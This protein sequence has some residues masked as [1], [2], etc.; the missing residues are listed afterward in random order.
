MNATKELRDLYNSFTKSPE[1]AWI[2][3]FPNAVDLYNFI[4]QCPIK[5]VLGLGT[6]IGLSDAIIAL[7]WKNKGEKEAKLITVEQY[8]KCIRLAK[9][10]IPKEL[11]T[12]IE[13]FKSEPT[14]WAND[15]LPYLYFSVYKELPSI[16]GGF[17]LIINDGPSPFVDAKGYYVDIPNGT[18]H[19]L[20][21]EDQIKPGSYVIYDG[22]V[23]S[24]NLLERYFDKCYYICT[25]P[26]LGS[27]FF[28]LE[29]KSSPVE[30]LDVKYEAMKN[31]TIYFKNHEEQKN[32]V[33][34]DKQSPSGKTETPVAGTEK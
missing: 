22:R 15:K 23:S 1:A 13:F 20:T 30:V 6:G 33:S 2:M 21:L 25:V 32:I 19:K 27:D 12:Y 28:L 24:I 17:D 34:S 14:V 10:L 11:Q 16:E 7:A 9:E 18:I 8:D 26:K 31:Q 3:T 29:R 5:K 4:T